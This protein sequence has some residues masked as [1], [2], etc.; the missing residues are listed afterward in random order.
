VGRHTISSLDRLAALPHA[1]G[2]TPAAYGAELLDYRRTAA[3]LILKVYM[4]LSG[5]ESKSFVKSCE[6]SFTLLC[7]VIYGTADT[8]TIMDPNR[9]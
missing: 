8:I 6:E 7:I 4:T 2:P 5:K 1:P 3:G 9:L